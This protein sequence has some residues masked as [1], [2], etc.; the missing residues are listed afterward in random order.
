MF[1]IGSY[2]QTS[3]HPHIKGIVDKVIEDKRVVR[4]LYYKSNG[5]WMVSKFS[6]PQ[7]YS[8]S[9]LYSGNIDEDET[10]IN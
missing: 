2:V 4:V 10:T 7:K 9:E 1:P 6:L 3:K 8:V 5:L